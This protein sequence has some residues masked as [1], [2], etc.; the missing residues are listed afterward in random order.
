MTDSRFTAVAFTEAGG[1]HFAS[2]SFMQ[3]NTQKAI[4][5]SSLT[6]KNELVEMLNTLFSKWTEV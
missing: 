3:G 4:R 1:Y 2:V 6:S 5:L